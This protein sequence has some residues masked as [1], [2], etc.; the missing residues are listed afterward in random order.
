MRKPNIYHVGNREMY[1]HG[2]HLLLN[3]KYFFRSLKWMWQRAVRGYADCDL[4]NLDYYLK[5]ILPSMLRDFTD[6]TMGYPMRYEHAINGAELWHDELYEIAQLIDNSLEENEAYPNIYNEEM[7]EYWGKV[8][9][10]CSET[11][12]TAWLEEERK[13]Q[14]KRDT[15]FLK[16]WSKLG[17]I[18][19]E[20]WD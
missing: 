7:E 3:L 17:D 14:I 5:S 9:D 8:K 19:D 10:E 1:G 12:Q 15:D 6:K 2:W 20:L 16:A 18:F 4:W 13:C 11:L